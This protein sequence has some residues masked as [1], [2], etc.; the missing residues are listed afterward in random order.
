MPSPS[1]SAVTFHQSLDP[2][3]LGSP[4]ADQ[5]AIQPQIDGI[6]PETSVQQASLGS[7]LDAPSE[8]LF[9]ISQ[10]EV[11]KRT[12]IDLE[13]NTFE[14]YTIGPMMHG[15][16]TIHYANG[17]RY[18]GNFVNNQRSG[19]GVHENQNKHQPRERLRYSG[20]WLKD[21]QHGHGVFEKIQLNKQ[22]QKQIT[23]LYEGAWV[24]GK[25]TGQGTRYFSDSGDSGPRYVGEVI[26][27]QPHGQGEMVYDHSS[28]FRV[29]NGTWQQGIRSGTGTM[30]YANKNEYSGEWQE[31][32]P[33]GKGKMK[34]ADGFSYEGEWLNG[35]RH[36]QGI[37]ML[38]DGKA[39]QDEWVD[40]QLQAS[41]QQTGCG[42]QIS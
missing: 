27:G 35:K 39:S 41:E 20:S 18:E 26:D 9:V 37:L 13:G 25:M 17:A 23:T 19:Y 30:K 16:G 2:L 22:A 38:A 28:S 40:D 33:N 15:H 5:N 29:Y 3:V 11:T 36:G 4:I 21:R 24:M 14:G 31:G 8:S 34:Y 12:I 6:S 32:Q 42:C 1:L 7:P 10:H